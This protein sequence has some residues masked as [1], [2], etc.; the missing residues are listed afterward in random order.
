MV[1]KMFWRFAFRKLPGVFIAIL[2]LFVCF[3]L[4][5]VYALAAEADKGAL[6]TPGELKDRL[7][8]IKWTLGLIVITAGLFTLAQ[9][10][11]AGFSAQSFTR[12]AEDTLSDL[13]KLESDVH[14]RYPFFADT[15]ERRTEAYENLTRMLAASSV[16]DAEEGFDWRR[17]S[18]ATRSLMERQEI[19][20]F[21]RLVPYEI[22]SQHESREVYSLQIQRLARF[23]WSKFVFEHG[24][25]LGYFADLER[26]EYLLELALRKASGR[27]SI[28]NDLG[29]IRLES[30]RA[31]IAVQDRD[32]YPTPQSDQNFNE[33]TEA[34]KGAIDTFEA[35]IRI[36][37]QQLRARYNL[38]VLYAE[39]LQNRLP[40][41][42]EELEKGVRWTNWETR[43]V[44][45]F[46]CTAW[47]NLGCYYG[48]LAKEN[49][50]LTL[51]NKCIAALEDAANI[52]LLAPEDVNK[53][54]FSVRAYHQCQPGTVTDLIP[55]TPDGD[56]YYLARHG[57]EK[58]KA[59]LAR[60]RPLL[61]AKRNPDRAG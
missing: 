28:Y 20:A 6:L 24:R 32:L 9:G 33:I 15:E 56:L 29:N 40:D 50:K 17:F 54:F 8:E 51:A 31:R 34:F 57:S 37:P 35:S 61:S 11:A 42:I 14:R 30:A 13:K 2:I 5:N 44:P 45:A 26:A 4:R 27:V 18:Y 36:Q 60:L 16:N 21:E 23:Y 12:Q 47:F 58:T 53:E 41:A 10:V 25:G 46:T 39:D 49:P 48:R 19:L 38:A 43:P 3:G 52:G 1:V 7:D 22:A 55:N 59:E